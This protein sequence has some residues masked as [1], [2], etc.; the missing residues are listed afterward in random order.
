MVI[1]AEVPQM[2]LGI[3]SGTKA[4]TIGLILLTLVI[5]PEK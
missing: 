1:R 5:A 4:A 2:A 3:A